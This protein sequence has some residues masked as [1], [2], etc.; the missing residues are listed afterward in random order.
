MR[1]CFFVAGTAVLV[2]FGLL[3]LLAIGGIIVSLVLPA[4]HRAK[5][6]A[7]AKYA[8]A[9]NAVASGMAASSFVISG[10]SD[11][12]VAQVM[13]GESAEVQLGRGISAEIV[14][15]LR[16]PRESDVWLKPDGSVFETAPVEVV[17]L[18][19][20]RTI[21]SPGQSVEPE[22]EV[23]VYYRVHTPEGVSMESIR[24]KWRPQPLLLQTAEEFPT[25]RD[26]GKLSQMVAHF[27]LRE[28]AS[29]L[30][31]TVELLTSDALWEPVAEFDGART[32]ELLPNAMVV[33]SPP[34][35]D[36]RAK[37]YVIDVMHNLS[38]EHHGLRLVAHLKGGRREEI[39]FHTGVLSGTPTKGF[40]L[41]YPDEVEVDEVE[42]WVLERTPWLRGEIRNIALQPRAAPA[43]DATA[44][45]ATFSPVIE[46]VLSQNSQS[47]VC[48][49]DLDDNRVFAPPSS[50]LSMEEL[51]QWITS[52]GIDAIAMTREAGAVQGLVGWDMRLLQV[53]GSGWQDSLPKALAAKLE[54]VQPLREVIMRGE[55][56]LPATFLLQTREG[57]KGVLQIT[58]FTDNPR[59][60][61]IR[62]KLVKWSKGSPPV[63]TS[64]KRQ[65]FV[66]EPG[67][68]DQTS[69]AVFDK[70][71]FL[72][73]NGWAVM[74]RMTI[75]GVAKIKLPGETERRCNIELLKGDDTSLTIRIYDLARNSVMTLSLL[76]DQMGEITVDGAGY[77]VTYLSVYVAN[78]KPDTS[79]FA[80]VVVTPVN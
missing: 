42:K 26:A 22:D 4:L 9:T 55:N 46:R 65:R 43:D 27:A 61:K 41:V 49:I 69:W 25:V 19:E 21:D 44:Y 73:S 2:W 78:D 58:G 10:P 71:S 28:A 15:V 32:K 7:T 38:R 60:V 59:G 30:N 3:L 16:N 75:G 34:R 54:S 51:N 74:S 11:H 33:F 45:T 1:G 17:Q 72:N 36:E 18:A 64:S 5:S 40:A 52:K 39:D 80:Q 31:L 12:P 67:M 62:Y 20:P 23:L 6:Q 53:D 57:G 76:R 56:A 8:D 79:A 63:T 14:G 47:D 50:D 29:S 77:R 70:P 37:R 48:F 24:M 66:P 13:S 35:F 68:A